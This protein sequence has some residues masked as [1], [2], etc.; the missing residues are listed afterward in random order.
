MADPYDIPCE[1]SSSGTDYP[2]VILQALEQQ[3]QQ[4]ASVML[5]IYTQIDQRIRSQQSQIVRVQKQITRVVNQQIRI[6]Q[7]GIDSVQQQLYAQIAARLTEQGIRI[8]QLQEQLSA[9]RPGVVES[10][11]Q[12]P[13]GGG[14]EVFTSISA[15]TR[16]VNQQLISAPTATQTTIGGTTE[17]FNIDT[18]LPPSQPQVPPPATLQPQPLPFPGVQQPPTGQISVGGVYQPVSTIINLPP[19]PELIPQSINPVEGTITYTPPVIEAIGEPTT[20]E[21]VVDPWTEPLAYRLGG[22]NRRW[23]ALANAYMGPRW[24]AFQMA[25][26][27]PA[28]VSAMFSTR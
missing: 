4:L 14:G 27:W 17:L 7:Q 15:P 16:T 25:P 13:A 3:Q 6:Q 8:T 1:P 11:G 26:T 28:A 2:G 10:A 20:N 24:A 12:Q 9:C 18:N 23:R 5:P 21:Q 19:V 22:F